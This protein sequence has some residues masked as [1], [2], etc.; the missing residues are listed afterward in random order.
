MRSI[1]SKELNIDGQTLEGRYIVIKQS[2]F[3]DSYTGSRV[4]RVAKGP[5]CSN[6]DARDR[7]VHVEGIG[8]VDRAKVERFA[9][10]DEIASV[11]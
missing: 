9:S 3:G 6:A 1:W 11:R 2:F 5:G 7:A 10:P 8:R 4:A